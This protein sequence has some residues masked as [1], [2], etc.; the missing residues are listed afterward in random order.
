MYDFLSL[1]YPLHAL[2]AIVWVGGMFFA[3]MALRPSVVV[4]EGPDRLR[5]WA[6]VFPRFFFWVWIAIAFLL[7]TGYG[8]ILID[9]GD[10]ASAPVHIH[11]MQGTGLI[12][13]AL[14]TYMYFGPFN[15]FKQEVAA[16]NWETAAICQAGIRR[17]VTVN[18][19]IGI[20]TALIG[21]SRPFWS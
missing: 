12:M 17:I 13:M 14:F 8:I 9:F 1:A 4:L 21:S 6:Q 7:I 19:A 5:L 10:M 15:A 11:I 16:E 20:I 3:H 18:L 2:S